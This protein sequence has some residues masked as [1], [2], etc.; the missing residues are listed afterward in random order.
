MDAKKKMSRKKNPHDYGDR[1]IIIDSGLY[2]VM[3]LG[4]G[5]HVTHVVSG[6]GKSVFKGGKGDAGYKKAMTKLKAMKAKSG[7]KKNPEIEIRE[8]I[9]Y[10]ENSEPLSNQFYSI[11]KNLERK[12]KRG[13]YDPVLAAKLWKYWI[14]EAVKGYN[15]E[16]LGGGRSLVQNVFTIQDRKDAAIVVERQ[17]RDDVIRGDNPIRKRSAKTSAAM[18]RKIKKV[19]KRPQS[20]ILFIFD[21]NNIWYVGQTQRGKSTNWTKETAKKNAYNFF[22]VT[23]ATNVAETVVLKKGEQI[24]IAKTSDTLQHIRNVIGQYALATGKV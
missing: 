9:L 4:D 1:W 15:A 22:S 19:G 23:G 5:W 3:F 10:A 16:V 20:H 13:I 14:D 24:G 12:H 18:H 8:L 11:L 6:V 7:R 21:G 2:E 17:W